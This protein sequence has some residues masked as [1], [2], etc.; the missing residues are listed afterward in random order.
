MSPTQTVQLTANCGLCTNVYLFAAVFAY[1]L[2]NFLCEIPANIWNC[3]TRAASCSSVCDQ[4]AALCRSDAT[5]QVPINIC[6]FRKILRA[7]F[8]FFPPAVVF[9]FPVSDL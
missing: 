9:R 8:L 6:S 2:S 1:Y 3:Q 5:Y 7:D 4:N